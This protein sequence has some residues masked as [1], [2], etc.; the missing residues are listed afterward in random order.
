MRV[1]CPQ[2]IRGGSL[3]VDLQQ[4]SFPANLRPDVLII[5]AG[6]AGLAIAADLVRNGADVVSA[7]DR[8]NGRRGSSQVFF[9]AAI[10]CGHPIEC[11]HLGRLRV[12]GGTINAWP[13]QQVPFDQV[14]FEQ[15]PWVSDE[16]WLIN[17]DALES[18]YQT[19]AEMV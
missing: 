1:G 18:Y 15:R 13:K 17:R 2:A 12:V 6:A 8:L 16:T 5:G 7:G 11:L 9:E 3:L 19:V 14:V 10:W 4:S